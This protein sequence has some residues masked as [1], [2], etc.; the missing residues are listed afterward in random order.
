[1]TLKKYREN[2]GITQYELSKG[3]DIQIRTI[4][5]IEYKNNTDLKKAMRI[6]KF[7]NN[8]IECIF[9]GNQKNK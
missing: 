8:T 3:T 7:F 1:M 9:F 5:N 6:A 4:Q 2:L